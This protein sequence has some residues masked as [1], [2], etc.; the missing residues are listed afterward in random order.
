VHRFS[1]I[2]GD[3]NVA[4]PIELTPDQLTVAGFRSAVTVVNDYTE[5][6][7][8]SDGGT[9]ITD[10]LTAENP[11]QTTLVSPVDGFAAIGALATSSA[12][13]P[14]GYNTL[15][16]EIA[17]TAPPASGSDPLELRFHID[18][19]LIGEIA[20]PLSST[21]AFRNGAPVPLCSEPTQRVASPD[22]CVFRLSPQADGS[23]IIGIYS[24]HASRWNFGKRITSFTIL[25]PTLPAGKRG[26]AYA[27]TLQAINGT[28]PLKWKKLTKL[29]KG[30]K[31]RAKTGMISG[32]PKVQGTFTFRVQATDAKKPK[33]RRVT[34]K[35][36]TI[37]IT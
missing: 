31:L 20:G 37:R 6:V 26:H 12:S 14:P 21:V 28:A 4:N 5:T 1:L 17:V 34:T 8:P 18:E 23:V 10:V 19:S 15:P 33:P 2:L 29:P 27:A 32:T 24:S 25:T 30:L 13:T 36:F 16:Q 9:L 11:I 22:P 7:F 3:A 35:T